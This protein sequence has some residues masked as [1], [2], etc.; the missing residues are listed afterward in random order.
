MRDGSTPSVAHSPRMSEIRR[1]SWRFWTSFGEVLVVRGW[2]R[3][4]GDEALALQQ[5]FARGA[6]DD[7]LRD[8]A[9]RTSLLA[10]YGDLVGA[11]PYL[12]P[13]EA[14]PGLAARLARALEQGEIVAL[15][16]PGASVSG[17]GGGTKKD[18]KKDDPPPAKEKTWIRI[19]VIDP[20][21]KPVA[22]I[23]YAMKVPDGSSRSGKVDGDGEADI[24]GI[25]PGMCELSLDDLDGGDWRLA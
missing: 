22:G 6:L 15:R 2:D 1:E 14:T 18:E 10:L 16:V 9:Q 23:A 12:V 7:W 11:A 13:I 19:K 25:D 5:A 3:Q 21:D 20:D 4:A 17:G 24:D 8:P